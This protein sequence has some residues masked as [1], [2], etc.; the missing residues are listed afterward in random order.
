MYIPACTYLHVF[1][2]LCVL[3]AAPYRVCHS[4]SNVVQICLTEF[5]HDRGLPFDRALALRD[6]NV[7]QLNDSGPVWRF[8]ANQVWLLFQ[9][10]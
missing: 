2:G 10:D 3:V 5:T 4:S 8:A 9:I 1:C 6:A 7:R